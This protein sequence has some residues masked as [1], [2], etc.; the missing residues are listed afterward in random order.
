MKRRAISKSRR[1]VIVSPVATIVGTALVATMLAALFPNEHQLI[2]FSEQHQKDDLSLAYLKLLLKLHPENNEVR[3]ALVENYT[4]HG[5]WNDARTTIEPLLKAEDE[6]GKRARLVA[7]N[8]DFAIA[9]KLVEKSDAQKNLFAGIIKA[10]ETYHST[11]NDT[12]ALKRMATISLALNNPALAAKTYER[13]AEIDKTMHTTWLK[14]AAEQWLASGASFKAAIHYQKLASEGSEKASRQ[15]T[16]MAL[17]C[18][19]K[20][21]AYSHALELVNRV[22]D[23]FRNDSEA[24]QRML[25]LVL[26]Q[27]DL[28]QAQQLAVALTRL[29]PEE[30]EMLTKRRNIEIAAN[31]LDMAYD[32]ALRIVEI[33]PDNNENRAMLA[34]LADW[35][36][37]QEAALDQW[38]WNVEHALTDEAL[39]RAMSITVAQENDAKWLQLADTASRSRPLDDHEVGFLE[40]IHLRGK[41]AEP[42]LEFLKT[43]Q[44]R[45]KLNVK[46][47]EVLAKEQERQGELESAIYTLQR[48]RQESDKPDVYARK[49][50]NIY[51]QAGNPE[52][53]LETLQS[54]PE[55]ARGDVK[56]FELLGDVAWSAG[57]KKEALASYEK[58]W[59]QGSTSVLAAERL[60]E[61]YRKTENPKSAVSVARE[62]FKRTGEARWLLLAMDVSASASLWTELRDAA[63]AAKQEE[64]R[65]FN[66]EQYWML[67]AYL[68]VHDKRKDQAREAYS[69]A[70]RINPE[71]TSAQLQ[72]LWF[73]IDQ[74]DNAQLET[75]LQQYQTTAK[76]NRNYW[77]AYAAGWMKLQRYSDALPW[78]ALQ[79]DAMQDDFTWL[80]SYADVAERAG[81]LKEA[82]RLRAKVLSKLKPRFDRSVPRSTNEKGDPLLEKKMAMTYAELVGKLEGAAAGNAALT[83]LLAQGY[84]D[85]VIYETLISAFLS[86]QNHAAALS[87]L[88]Q[89]SAKG[90][91]LPAWQLLAV[92]LAQDDRKAIAEIISQR[93]QELSV[94]DRVTALRRLN[95]NKLAL[96]LTE[97]SLLEDGGGADN[98]MRQHQKA[99]RRQLARSVE[100]R[101][102]RRR[103]ADLRINTSEL[104]VSVPFDSYRMKARAARSNLESDSSFLAVDAFENDFSVS[105]ESLDSNN[106]HSFLIGVSQRTGNSLFYGRANATKRLYSWLAASVDLA[107]NN[108]TEET[109]ALRALGSKDKLSLNL[110]VNSSN[111][112]YGR[113][114]L[115]AQRFETRQGDLLGKGYKIEGEVGD[116]P[117]AN[118]RNWQVRI[119][120][121]FEENSLVDAL[122]PALS[123]RELAAGTGIET[124]LAR[125]FSTLGIGSTYRF[126]DQDLSEKKTH[127]MVDGWVGQQWPI[128]ELG[129]SVRASLNTAIRQNGYVRLEGFY[130]NVQGGVSSQASRGAAIWYMHEF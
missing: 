60:I 99:L 56:Y 44:L 69:H 7:I 127:G 81:Q 108:L 125:R 109:P 121:S 27:N 53:A 71:S 62:A 68:A 55:A 34:R 30:P 12:N 97:R 102:E 107:V 123:G 130:T 94:A 23:R 59:S 10:I 118:M 106:V 117:I 100:A 14:L 16:L 40:A 92:A 1:P 119:A 18:F 26:Q 38:L 11:T 126:G 95:R 91:R 110:Y 36:G 21:D 122:P 39:S 58:A 101:I 88:Q 116:S 48:L 3:F 35:T 78:F 66:N 45:H 84:D 98:L 67:Q 74:G 86:E 17:D 75:L 113:I 76:A 32:T 129:Y 15:N 105:V 90:H 57:R 50:A 28:R 19:V 70:L 65:F 112:R 52:K 83:Q 104:A 61:E 89:A 87:F 77:G 72:L 63:D 37:K 4:G 93:E 79:E 25:A 128:D 103:L 73:E 6:T 80:L 82:Q 124:I 111:A 33:E 24:L 43:Y 42:L 41:H 120:G 54:S 96:I 2:S 20:A 29:H 51:V 13:L 64:K 46:G 8:V 5:E 114:G 9:T 31:D 115:A 49:Q 22:S 85:P 47:L